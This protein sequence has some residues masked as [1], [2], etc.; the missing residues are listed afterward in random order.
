MKAILL[1]IMP[2]PSF[3]LMLVI[4]SVLFVGTCT[5]SFMVMTLLGTTLSVFMALRVALCTNSVAL[6]CHPDPKAGAPA[7]LC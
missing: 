5:C 7:T 3:V 4:V 2:I 1:M 6:L